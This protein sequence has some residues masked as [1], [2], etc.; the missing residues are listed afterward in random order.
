MA[1]LSKF[2]WEAAEKD[3]AAPI[4]RREV[5]AGYLRAGGSRVNFRYMKKVTDSDLVPEAFLNFMSRVLDVSKV[6]SEVAAKEFP[7][8]IKTAIAAKTVVEG[9]TYQMVQMSF[10]DPEQKKIN[11]TTDS[12]FSETWFYLKNGHRWVLT[13]VNGSVSKVQV[14]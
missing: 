14:Y 8:A 5:G 10:G 4:T 6:Q 7:T 11:D 12:T 1:T 3:A 9:M 2:I 13:F